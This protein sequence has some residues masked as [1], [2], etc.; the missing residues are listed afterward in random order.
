MATSEE[1]IED[2]LRNAFS[3]ICLGSESNTIS[4]NEVRRKAEQQLKLQHG[5]LK[6]GRWKDKSRFLILA[7]NVRLSLFYVPADKFRPTSNA[8]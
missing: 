7:E 6:Y 5:F 4:L 1:A 2:A 8:D 3:S